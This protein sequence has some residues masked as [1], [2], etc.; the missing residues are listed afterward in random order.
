MREEHLFNI[1]QP[2][3]KTFTQIHHFSRFQGNPF[4]WPRATCGQS[5]SL[6]DDIKFELWATEEHV[7]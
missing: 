7:K 2:I 4:G 5:E 6:P 1:T 3:L